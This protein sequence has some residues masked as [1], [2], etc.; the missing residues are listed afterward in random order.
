MRLPRSLYNGYNS[1]RNSKLVVKRNNDDDALTY[2]QNILNNAQPVD[3]DDVVLYKFVR[4]L[5]NE[6]RHKF[7]SF[8]RN[9]SFECLIMWTDARSIVNFLGLRW[10]IRIKWQNEYK[11]FMV[12]RVQPSPPSHNGRNNVVRHKENKYP[13]HPLAK[14]E[15]DQDLTTP[16]KW[17]DI[18]SSDEGE[19]MAE[20]VKQT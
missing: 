20:L 2:F 19:T 16:T 1:L 13:A 18:V 7:I 6:N 17:S 14:N 9:T 10:L 5:Y 4:G 3:Y 12:T 15:I 8:I 11:T